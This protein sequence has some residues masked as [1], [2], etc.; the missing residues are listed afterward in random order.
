MQVVTTM[1]CALA[2]GVPFGLAAGRV[3]WRAVAAQLGVATAPSVPGWP[4]AATV[5]G[6]LVLALAAA[7]LPAGLAAR[8]TPAV[9]LR[10]E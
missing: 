8:I 5:G 9:A 7:A 3:A 2:V 6:A 10:T 1:A 4:V